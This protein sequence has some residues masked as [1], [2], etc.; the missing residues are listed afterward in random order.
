M[1]NIIL[2]GFMGSGKTVAGRMLAEKLGVELFDTDELIVGKEGMSIADI[3]AKHG[4]PYFRRLETETVKS[5]AEKENS[6][7]SLGGGLAANEVNHPYLKEAG[8]V[9]LLDCGIEETLRRISGDASRPLTA[10]GSKDIEARYNFRKPIYM[11][12][13]DAVI[14]S[15]GEPEVTL[16]KILAVLEELK[17]I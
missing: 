15:S 17:Q 3:F 12:V 10:K 7:I 8:T 6:V 11:S 16:K 4:E 5:F 14:D 2:C 1:K 9:L 13:A